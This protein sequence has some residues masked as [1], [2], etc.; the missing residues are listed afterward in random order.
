MVTLAPDDGSETGTASPWGLPASH[1]RSTRPSGPIAVGAEIGTF[2]PATSISRPVTSI[3]A[4][5]C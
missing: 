3:V 1:F 2:C 4:E 5:E